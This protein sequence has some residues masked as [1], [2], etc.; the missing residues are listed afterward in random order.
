MVTPEN[1]SEF[2]P[3]LPPEIHNITVQDNPD[4]PCL[5]T[6]TDFIRAFLLEKFGGLYI[7]SDAIVLQSLKGLFEMI[8]K[9]H[10]I[11]MRK[12]SAPTRHISIGLYGSIANGE[13]ITS[14][15][16]ALR[17]HIAQRTAFKWGEVGAFTLTPII[18]SG[19]PNRVLPERDIQ[20]IPFNAPRILAS[21]I[22]E[23]E[24]FLDEKTLTLMLFHSVFDT[25]LKGWS[26]DKLYNSDA[27]ISKV[28]R[29][30]L[31]QR[32]FLKAEYETTV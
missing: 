16:N 8:R 25:T 1:L 24:D 11:S 19:L 10:F 29:A 32:E 30:T 22:H 27:L 18:D 28:F 5:A 14:Y 15:A 6:K 17:D 23:P 21:K 12:V 4:E 26:I 7:D 31:P 13:V 9:D 2:L 20:P 3:D